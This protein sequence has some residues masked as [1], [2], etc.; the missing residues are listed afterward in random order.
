MGMKA[1][2]EM[3]KSISHFCFIIIVN[4]LYFTTVNDKT[5][6]YVNRGVLRTHEEIVL[7]LCSTSGINYMILQLMKEIRK[8]TNITLSNADAISYV[9]Q[10]VS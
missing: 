5:F 6:H 10:R 2:Y 9:F 8:W 3:P 7:F 1:L 4:C